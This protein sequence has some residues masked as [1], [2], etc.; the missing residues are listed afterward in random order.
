MMTMATAK[1]SASCINTKKATAK[2][3]NT[4]YNTQ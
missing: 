3:T 2:T 1:N 4:K